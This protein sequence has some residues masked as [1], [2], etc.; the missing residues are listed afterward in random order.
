MDAEREQQIGGRL[1]FFRETLQISRTKFSVSCGFGSERIASYEAGRVPLPYQVFKAV[2]E[3]YFLRPF[4]LALGND[5]GA[6]RGLGPFDD[7]SFVAKLPERA[8]FSEVYDEF[9][10][11]FLKSV[12]D[13]ERADSETMK[14]FVQELIGRLERGTPPS[15]NEVMQQVAWLRTR[16]KTLDLNQAFTKKV[17]VGGETQIS[18]L[19]NTLTQFN[20]GGVKPLWPA[21]KRRLQSATAET[22]KK[23]ELA[24]FLRLDLT[25]VSQWLTDSESA[26]E[27]GA[28][29]ALQMLHWVELQERNQK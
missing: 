14:Q 3:R 22:G 7:S 4:W 8:L 28:E 13:A 16:P 10:A 1:R 27:P 2:S 24:K 23:S 20:I 21:L 6:A 15:A 29:Y 5:G 17:S 11:G 18:D 19:T 26:R 25:R 12:R 9:I